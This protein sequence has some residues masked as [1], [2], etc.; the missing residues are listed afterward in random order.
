MNTTCIQQLDRE[1]TH[2]IVEKGELMVEF[3]LEM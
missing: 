1:L 3:Y 2:L